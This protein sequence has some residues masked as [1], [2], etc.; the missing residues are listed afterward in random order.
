M[1]KLCLLAFAS[2]LAASPALA[3]KR[4]LSVDDIYNVKDVRNPERSPDG[5]W[6][7]F[8][9]SRAIKDTDKN[10]SD[11]WMASWDGTQEIQLTSTPESESTPRWSPDNRYL[12][13]V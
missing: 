8:V 5:K 13:F 10:D 1:K 3:Q 9:V 12:A 7:A 11:V 6:V 2:C 4:A